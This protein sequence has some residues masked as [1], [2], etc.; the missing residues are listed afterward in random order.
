MRR[1]TSLVESVRT[2][3][4]ELN[5]DLIEMHFRRMPRSYVES[6]SPSEIAGHLRMIALLE[7]ERPVDVEFR[8]QDS[9]T[10]E[11]VVVGEDRTGVLA[12]I[13]TALATDGFSLRDVKLATYSADKGSV[14]EPTYFVD[15]L[16]VAGDPNHRS[17][18]DHASA[19]RERLVDSFR[20]L[21]EGKMAEAQIAVGDSR[22]P[23]LAPTDKEFQIGQV[24]DERFRITQLIARS[25]MSS[26]YKAT[27]LSAG[28]PVALKVP[29]MEFESDPGLFSRFE[30]EE[31]V[32]KLL[33]HP[34]ILR[35]VPVEHKSRP[36]IAMEFLEGQTLRQRLS[37]G[38][39]LPVAE[40]LNIASRVCEALEYM[41]R[42]E[43]V[44]RDL[45]P[46]NIMLCKDGSLRIMDFGIVKVSGMRRLTFSGFSPALGTPDFMAPEQVKGKRG[47][48]RTDVYSLG[49][50]LFEMI[51]GTVPFEGSTPFQIMN[52]RLTGDPPAPRSINPDIP[53]EVEEIVLH[54]M[55]RNPDDRYPSAAAMKAELDA[56]EKVVV[57]GRH[58]HLQA[59]V[60]QES[61]WQRY[62][63]L[64][65]SL[66]VP[67]VIVG[68]FFLL[69]LRFRGR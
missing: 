39:K 16:R 36:Y 35:V 67:V 21:S 34:Y 3:C 5:S 24:V 53:P 47:D 1:M 61:F 26:V 68:L 10:Y 25:G 46:E 6:C 54:A 69:V 58:E 59:P 8:P 37:S 51:T 33:D 50:V 20:Y 55:Q 65:L 56:P 48:Q 15:I 43:M 32:G 28:S 60:L 49:A 14:G 63:V 19:L 13:T 11:V 45:K 66:L 62:Q 2:L 40:A 4:P 12:S 41:H 22:L 23:S 57:T 29:F 18:Q 17:T 44:H 42:Q 9:G 31:A 52:A 64:L 27:D 38:G 30:R 7:P